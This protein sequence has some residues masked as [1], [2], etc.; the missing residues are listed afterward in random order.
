MTTPTQSDEHKAE[1]E[2][3]AFQSAI[4]LL[5]FSSLMIMQHEGEENLLTFTRL[6]GVTIM[7]LLMTGFPE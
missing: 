4:K 3:D 1:G 5:S 6:P 2:D 7:H